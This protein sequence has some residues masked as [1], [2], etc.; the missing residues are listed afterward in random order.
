MACFG[1]L[2]VGLSIIF[3]CLVLALG[4]EVYYLLWR[5][6]KMA[7]IPSPEETADSTACYSLYAAKELLIQLT[8]WKKKK[9]PSLDHQQHC[10]GGD[11]ILDSKDGEEDPEL[12]VG[13]GSLT[14]QQQFAGD[15]ESVE[16]E[17]MRLHNL[18]GPPKFLFTITEETREDMESHDGRSSDVI[19]SLANTPL[20]TPLPSPTMKATLSLEG[21]S[22]IQLVDLYNNPLFESAGASGWRP[23]PSPPP[24]FKFLRDAEEKLYRRIKEEAE[25]RLRE[26]RQRET[27]VPPPPSGSSQVLPLESY[28]TTLRTALDKN[29]AQT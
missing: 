2:G 26:A 6:K 29:G 13:E 24:K 3:G 27:T 20:L 1:S 5:K 16:L 15:E 19:L 4:V 17:L 25:S 23:S 28:P 8:C 14:K 22:H 21:Y 12:A 9:K 7:I 18:A 10:S 11:R